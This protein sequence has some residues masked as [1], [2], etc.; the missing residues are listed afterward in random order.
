MY[1][2]RGGQGSRLTGSEGSF[3]EARS[4]NV[5]DLQRFYEK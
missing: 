5:R 3:A 2:H 4:Q 1:A